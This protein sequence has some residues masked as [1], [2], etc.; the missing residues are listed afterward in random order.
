MN[1]ASIY[2]LRCADGSFYTGVTRRSVE[3]RVSEHNSGMIPGFTSKRRPVALLFSETYA[4]VDEAIAAERRIRGWSRAKKIAYMRGDFDALSK[5]AKN[6]Q[7]CPDPS[8]FDKLRVRD[9]A[10]DQD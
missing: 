8:P 4:R 6:H 7:T 1:G 9:Q 10:Q 3:E 5:F 2:I